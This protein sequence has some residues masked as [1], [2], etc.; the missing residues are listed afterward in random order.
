M[1]TNTIATSRLPACLPLAPA[2]FL[3]LCLVVPSNQHS[4]STASGLET[5]GPG[6]DPALAREVGDGDVPVDSQ[7]HRVILYPGRWKIRTPVTRHAY[8]AYHFYLG[9]NWTKLNVNYPECSQIACIGLPD[10][11]RGCDHL[12]SSETWRDAS[13]ALNRA[14]REYSRATL[15]LDATFADLAALMNTHIVNQEMGP[16]SASNPQV[17]DVLRHHRAFIAEALKDVAAHHT[18]FDA[19]ANNQ[20][21]ASRSN[22]TSKFN[23]LLDTWKSSALKFAVLLNAVTFAL[24]GARQRLL[25]CAQGVQ[26][27]DM[28]GC[29]PDFITEFYTDIP[30]ASR[31]P[32]SLSSSSSSPTGLI[33][34]VER[35]HWRPTVLS[36]WYL[37]FIDSSNG[38]RTCWLDRPMVSDMHG[39]YRVPLCDW[40]GVCEPLERDY[41]TLSACEV[42]KSGEISLRCPV[43]C[44]VPCFGPICYQ[45]R[46]NTYTPRTASG[47]THDI[48]TKNN[49]TLVQ[50]TKSPRILSK[51]YSLSETDIHASLAGI[52]NRSTRASELLERGRTLL[53]TINTMAV[54]ARNYIGKAQAETAQEQSRETACIKNER[55]IGQNQIMAGASVT[56]SILTCPLLIVII[57]KNRSSRDSGNVPV[58]AR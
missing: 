23:K 33:M 18:A 19:F 27:A 24:Q 54:T 29:E 42:D 41:E 16:V 34:I 20:L 46:S 44:G 56:L 9:L 31:V 25:M 55:V 48:D 2:L 3:C 22:V 37:P 51:V 36:R 10:S 57:L 26:R 21:L 17:V 43:V 28:T 1:I 45:P 11:H 8:V 52:L 53:Q 49:L 38:N 35:D 5:P 50:V 14:T 15:R 39:N 40:R 12:C 4:S 13:I 30:V 58:W 6:L 7:D 32:S 47:G